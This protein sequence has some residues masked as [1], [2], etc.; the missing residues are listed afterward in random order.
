MNLLRRVND[1]LKA[2]VP[3][4]NVP[5]RT[6]ANDLMRINEDVTIYPY[7]KDVTFIEEGYKKNFAVHTVV[8]KCVNKF[9]Q[10]TFDHYRVKTDERKTWNEYVNLSRKDGILYD[11]RAVI[12]LR[13]MRQKSVE[14][15]MVISPMAK[16]LKKANRYQSGSK[17]RG[18]LYG[19]K[20][21]TGEGNIWFSRPKN[22]DG[23][24]N[25]S[26]PPTEMFVIPKAN[27]ALVKG[28]DAWD[29]SKYKL[30]NMPGEVP[31]EKGNILMWVFDTYG[32]DPLTLQHMR[33][34]APL[35]AG[36][37]MMQASN[38]GIKRLASMNKNQGASVI[39]SRE[40][41]FKTADGF[42]S[43]TLMGQMR[44]QFDNIVNSN[45]MAGKIAMLQGKWQFYQV[46]LDARS[47]E[48]LKQMDN[49]L[50][51]VCYLLDVPVGLFKQGTTYDNKPAEQ[52][53][54]IY[55]NIAPAAYEFRDLLNEKLIRE[56]NLDD[57]RDVIDCD[58]LQLPELAADQ[59]KQADFITKMGYRITGNEGRELAGFERSTDPNMDKHYSD[60]NM[61]TLDQL[62][63]DLGEPLD[64]NNLNL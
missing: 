6:F 2:S 12:E 63:A 61:Q 39:A 56:F 60:S 14:Q 13:K 52:K 23:T 5:S 20:L 46:G 11:Y 62:N 19:H 4:F 30:I 16:L 53:S 21:L 42:P 10:V 17:F 44:S 37:L 31:T 8:K 48:L 34:Q 50:D 9:S 24:F 49:A 54:F 3:T 32:L 64:L 51:V 22:A 59:V 58:I 41:P 25:M 47:L 1:Y 18:N 40:E 29:I 35:D 7:G 27:L 33:G 45:E 55:D 26:L 36:I 15:M 28:S 43:P 57:Q 38:E